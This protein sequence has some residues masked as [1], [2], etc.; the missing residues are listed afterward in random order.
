MRGFWYRTKSDGLGDGREGLEKPLRRVIPSSLPP[1]SA[2]PTSGRSTRR[3]RD[4]ANR[5]KRR[6]Y[7]RRLHEVNPEKRRD[8]FRRWYEANRDRV[9]ENNR[10]R[11][12][13]RR[14]KRRKQR[15]GKRVPDDRVT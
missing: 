12:Q 5:E 3:I 11:Y 7:A 15:A 8:Y 6:V 1:A 13:A 9:L 14:E 10:R 4:E 2:G